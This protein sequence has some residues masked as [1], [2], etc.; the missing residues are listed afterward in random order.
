MGFLRSKAGIQF[1]PAII[2]LLEEHYPKL[3]EMAR[4]HTTEME[5]LRT[6]ILI[7]RGVAPA[8][9]FALDPAILESAATAAEQLTEERDKKTANPLLAGMS[10][11]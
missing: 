5:P 8:A 2:K 3:E 6:D 9:G 10:A 4:A 11:S 7:E 1:D